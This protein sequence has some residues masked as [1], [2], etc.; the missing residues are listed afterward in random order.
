MANTENVHPVRAARLALNLTREDLA[1]RA[2]VTVR[3][4]ERTEGGHS[5]PHRVTQRALAAALDQDP[6]D[7]WPTQADLQEAA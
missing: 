3:T 7:L 2:G 6:G 5:V 1:S 4:V